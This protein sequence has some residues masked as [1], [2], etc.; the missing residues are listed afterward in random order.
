MRRRTQAWPSLTLRGNGQKVPHCLSD[1]MLLNQ[2]RC[3]IASQLMRNDFVPPFETEK[4]AELCQSRGQVFSHDNPPLPSFS[5]L[6]LQQTVGLHMELR[7]P[8]PE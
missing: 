2:R 6:P 1:V 8:R 7:A 4:Q 3:L 5:L